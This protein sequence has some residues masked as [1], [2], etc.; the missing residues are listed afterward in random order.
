MSD[1]LRRVPRLAMCCVV[2]LGLAQSARGQTA[3]DCAQAG[4]AAERQFGLPP[5]LL[6]A[7]GRVETGR[8]DA[9]RG[10]VVAWPWA[11]DVDGDGRLFENSGDAVV[12]ARAARAAGRHS[13]D[14][15][16]FQIN[17]LH[18]PDAFADLDQAF[19]PQANAE[20][21][22]RFL[23]SLRGRLGNWHDAVAAYHSATPELGL[24]YSQ[25]VFAAWS[26]TGTVAAESAA[27]FSGFPRIHVWGPSPAGTAPA[28]IAIHTSLPLLLPRVVTPGR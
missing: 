11:V 18:H 28:V 2:A 27:Q 4:R 9:R 10:R 3:L 5:G 15:G 7:I 21:A 8:W 6:R 13:I 25:R 23:A 20:Y 17:L 26:G 14:V 1:M 24:P 12:A 16:C 19:D 22:A